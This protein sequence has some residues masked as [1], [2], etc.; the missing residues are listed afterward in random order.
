M[1]KVRFALLLLPFITLSSCARDKLSEI[2]F[3]SN[4]IDSITQVSKSCEESEYIDIIERS[5]QAFKSDDDY[6]YKIEFNENITV[7]M[8]ICYKGLEGKT[9]DYVRYIDSHHLAVGLSGTVLDKTATFGFLRFASESFTP[10]KESLK[11]FDL[12]CK[13][14]IGDEYQIDVP[15]IY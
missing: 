9:I 4:E 5:N 8:I 13:L 14:R 6:E 11:G 2:L 10:I 12:L 3:S 1:K 15:H 7:D